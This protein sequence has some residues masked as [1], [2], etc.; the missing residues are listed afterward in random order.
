MSIQ[1]YIQFCTMGRTSGGEYVAKIQLFN[2]RS[3]DLPTYLGYSKDK[4]EAIQRAL[5]FV[6][7]DL[8]GEYSIG[9]DGDVITFDPSYNEMDNWDSDT[10]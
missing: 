10:E 5:E 8:G 2:T 1:I 4:Q 6:M 9:V 3:S 7:R